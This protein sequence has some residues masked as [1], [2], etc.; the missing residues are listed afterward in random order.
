V[1]F[2]IRPEGVGTFKAA[3]QVAL[4]FKVRNAKLPLPGLGKLDFRLMQ[5]APP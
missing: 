4:Q 3:E 1:I 5:G 2:L